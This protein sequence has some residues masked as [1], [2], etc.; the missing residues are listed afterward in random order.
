MFDLF[1]V[2]TMDLRACLKCG[3]LL[4]YNNAV[5]YHELTIHAEPG[6][7]MEEVVWL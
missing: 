6:E 4:L 7:F 1:V 2:H 3:G 5:L